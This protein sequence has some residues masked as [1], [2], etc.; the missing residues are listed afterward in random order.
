MANWAMITPPSMAAGRQE[1]SYSLNPIF[2]ETLG[3]IGG[4]FCRRRCIV[5]RIDFKEADKVI[6][7]LA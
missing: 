7:L 2:A 4:I 5:V 6:D 3:I 1:G